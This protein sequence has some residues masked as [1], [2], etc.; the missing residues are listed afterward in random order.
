MGDTFLHLLELPMIDL[1]V[2]IPSL[3]EDSPAKGTDN[4]FEVVG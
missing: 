3:C 1:A 2:T 4:G